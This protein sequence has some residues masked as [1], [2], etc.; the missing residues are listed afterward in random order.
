MSLRDEDDEPTEE[1]TA[2][3]IVADEMS[4]C[5]QFSCGNIFFQHI[6]PGAAEFILVGD[7]NQLP[8]VRAGNVL[9]ELINSKRIA[10]TWLDEVFRQG[11]G[12]SIIDNSESINDG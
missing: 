7:V 12:S 9:R 6:K 5:D 3:W 8:S 2:D 10:T 1:L 11:E 4:M